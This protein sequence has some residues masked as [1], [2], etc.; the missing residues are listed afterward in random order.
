MNKILGTLILVLLMLGSHST[1]LADTETRICGEGES[2]SDGCVIVTS[3]EEDEE[4]EEEP[5][6]D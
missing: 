2:E 6:C 3:E 1:V 5:E 4:E